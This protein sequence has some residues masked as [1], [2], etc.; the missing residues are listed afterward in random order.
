MK[1]VPVIALMDYFSWRRYIWE[2]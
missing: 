2:I 1:H